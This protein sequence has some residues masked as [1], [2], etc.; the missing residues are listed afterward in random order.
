MPRVV[1]TINYH[2]EKSFRSVNNLLVNYFTQTLPVVPQK[3]DK[4]YKFNV[5]DK[6]RIDLIP[7]QRKS[8]GF[9]YSLNVGM[10]ENIFALFAF[11]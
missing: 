11:L 5:D 4:F 2:S 10:S 7:S 3:V 1:D 6:V 8:L 9:K